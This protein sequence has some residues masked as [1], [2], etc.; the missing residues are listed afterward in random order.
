MSDLYPGMKSKLYF[1]ELGLK[2]RRSGFIPLWLYKSKIYSH[3]LQISLKLAIVG[4]V[5]R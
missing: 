4:G 5:W 1:T 2:F 3:P